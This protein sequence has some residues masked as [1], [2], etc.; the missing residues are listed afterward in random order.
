VCSPTYAATHGRL[1]APLQTSGHVLLH[2]AD[3]LLDWDT[4]WGGMA[5]R[6]APRAIWLEFSDYAVV[7]QG[8]MNGE[9]IALGWITVVARALGEGRLVPASD[10][11]VR[12]GRDY[13]LFAPRSKPVREVVLAIRDWM[14]AQ[15]REDMERVAAL[16]G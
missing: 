4:L 13:H 5:R 16:L 7:L 10:R 8:A 12:T 1:E 14:I 3:P 15:M 9:G 11:R 2:L 6:R